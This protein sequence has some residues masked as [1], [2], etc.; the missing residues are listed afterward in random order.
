[1][2]ETG[3]RLTT[4]GHTAGPQASLQGDPQRTTPTM[5]PGTNTAANSTAPTIT[6]A[7]ITSATTTTAA[8]NIIATAADNGPARARPITPTPTPPAASEASHA[9]VQNQASPQ[10]SQLH[11]LHHRL[12]SGHDDADENR[13]NNH[14]AT[15]ASVLDQQSAPSSNSA[16]NNTPGSSDLPISHNAPTSSSGLPLLPQYR[17]APQTTTV[18]PNSV[19]P[20]RD[21]PSTVSHH[22]QTNDTAQTPEAPAQQ[23]QQ[24]QSSATEVNLDT[25]SVD[26]HLASH[27][28]R[29][30]SAPRSSL[31]INTLDGHPA[32]V[33][34]QRAHGAAEGGT[35]SSAA[36][37]PDT[38]SSRDSLQGQRELLLVKSLSSLS[39]PSDE[40]RA[41][42]LQQRPP[43]SYKPPPNAASTKAPSA[44]SSVS[45]TSSSPAVRVPPIRSFRSSGSRKSLTLDMNY[46]RSR[47]GDS[48]ADE[49]SDDPEN[50]RTLRALEG[51]Q[52]QDMLQMTPPSSARHGDFNDADDGGDVFLRIAREEDSHRAASTANGNMADETQSPVSRVY[53]SHR[54]PLSTNVATY[55]PKSPPFVGR[56]LSDQRDSP[57]S[58]VDD[59]R[60][61]EITRSMTLRGFSRDHPKAA[62]AH[63]GDATASPPRSTAPTSLRP[64]PL[65][66]RAVAY[67]DIGAADNVSNNP[68]PQ[69][70]R[71]SVTEH[72]VSPSVRTSTYRSSGSRDTGPGKI[73]SS[74]PLTRSFNW[75]QGDRQGEDANGA[76]AANGVEGTE[77]TASNTAPSTVWDELDDL[78]SRIHR[79][80][81]TG[82]LPATSG[83]AVSRLTDERPPTAATTATTASSS[84]K[85]SRETGPQNNNASAAAAAAANNGKD[86]ASETRGS[87]MPAQ[88]EAYPILVSALSKSKPFL[89]LEIFRALESAANDAMSLAS[90]MG[91][92]GEPGPISSGASAIGPGGAVVTDRQ[93]RR[94]A[95]SV[96][97]SLTE[98]CVALGEDSAHTRPQTQ[99]AA[100]TAPSQIQTQTQAQTQ[101]QPQ[102]LAP[103]QTQSSSQGL[104]QYHPSTSSSQADG[105][106][107]PTIHKSFSGLHSRRP[108]ISSGQGLRDPVKQ[109]L[110]SPRSVSKFE[111]RRNT[112]L[113]GGAL[114]SP[115]T[116]VAS[117]PATPQDP[118]VSRRSS[119]LIARTRRAVTEEPEDATGRKS[120]LLRTRRAGTEE[121]EEERQTAIR[122]A[123]RG[124]TGEGDDEAATAAAA[125][126]NFRALSRAFT[127]V[128][129]TR[130]QPREYTEVAASARGPTREYSTVSTTRDYASH[131]YQEPLSPTSTEQPDPNV[132]STL[133]RRRFVSSHATNA[134]LSAASTPAPGATSS[135][136]LPTRKNAG[137][138]P[139]S[140]TTV[141]KER[142]HTAPPTSRYASLGQTLFPGRTGNLS[143]RRYNRDSSIG[144][145]TTVAYNR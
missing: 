141:P 107:T 95:D 56:R 65:A 17:V 5:S 94:K 36:T 41:S 124:T 46:Y 96:C 26:A 115:R 92:P 100:N 60:A 111:E 138:P 69:H 126:S 109:Q 24:Q 112:I 123:R 125:A 20:D 81:L 6:T 16:T 145:G 75:Q 144:T 130:G 59:K 106:S 97:R 53:R 99:K 136:A 67:Y 79:L 83:A 85:R 119:L 137:P 13:H 90:M 25:P 131:R 143:T 108:S 77:S 9:Q 18:S 57:R 55:Q 101:S 1:M 37:V 120:S 15:I 121:P 64:S 117:T 89:H 116:V 128:N 23:R 48:S 12:G 82:K 58:R 19:A 71:S 98:L 104:T 3:V 66:P 122:R 62:F 29:R 113:N 27:P 84:P 110:A 139:T 50:D 105:P 134:R 76:H 52:I 140:M 47:P 39:N 78:K 129:A 22:R 32:P 127:E 2:A 142:D 87:I 28:Q 42:I 88:K 31:V 45:S 35:S 103:I 34:T 70:R 21:S 11:H 80:E 51:R 114:P 135:S 63:P 91:Q 102:V 38:Q 68:I 40:R 133:P 4:A 33:R 93:L 14:T 43:V 30:A 61:S 86:N 54:R 8:T 74:S 10:H 49:T 44:S 72:I 7:A 132:P 73:Y 118:T